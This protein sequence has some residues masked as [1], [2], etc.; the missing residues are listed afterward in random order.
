MALEGGEFRQFSFFIDNIY[1]P[2]KKNRFM[3]YIPSIPQIN[4][5]NTLKVDGTTSNQ[6]GLLLSLQTA[7]RPQYTVDTTEIQR[8]NEKAFWA[9]APAHD[10]TMSCT[11]N[12]Y[13][14]NLGDPADSN[15]NNAAVVLYRWYNTIYNL[16]QGS[17]GFKAE[18]AT[19]AN[20]YLIDPHGNAIEQWHYIHL[21]PTDINYESLE[22]SSTDVCTIAV[23][24]KY[25]KVR[26][27]GASDTN[28]STE[29]RENY[30]QETGESIG[31]SPNSDGDSA[32][33][34]T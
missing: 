8:Y 27:L 4:D 21:Y 28:T 7:A 14:D 25:D 34:T 20:L 5:T 18:Y 15:T 3:L 32:G 16:A 6:S 9:S 31:T 13:I 29:A 2:K 11:F 23:T 12:D 22:M 17:M 1:E 33:E 19:T 24:F 10:K 30:A 26:L